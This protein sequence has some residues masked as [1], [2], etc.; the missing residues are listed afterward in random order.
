MLHPA[1][2]RAL[3]TARIEELHREA[4]RRH[5]IDLAPVAHEPRVAAARG[6]AIVSG[7]WWTGRREGRSRRDR[8]P[9]QREMRSER[10]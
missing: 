2:A 7:R 8:A 4:A 10:S 1:L 6:V 5:T 9:M 3:A